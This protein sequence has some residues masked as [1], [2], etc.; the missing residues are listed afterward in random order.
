MSDLYVECSKRKCKWQ[1]WE[2]ELVR[3]PSRDL[4][5]G[6]WDH[7]CPKCG[8]DSYYPLPEPHPASVDR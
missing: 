6:A 5:E 7:T 3:I 2:S 1:G 8:N 4:G